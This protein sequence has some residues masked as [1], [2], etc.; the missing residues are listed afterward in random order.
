MIEKI[1]IFIV[2]LFPLIFFHELGHFFFA[3]LFKVRVSTFSIGFGRKIFTFNKWDTQ[4]AVSLIPLGGYVKMYGEDPLRREEIPQYEREFSFIHKAKWQRFLILFGGPLANFILAFVLYFGLAFQ[5][6]KVPELKIG[7]ISQ[8]SSYYE[9]GLRLG[10]TLFQ[11]NQ[12]DFLGMASLPSESETIETLTVLRNHEPY[13]FSLGMPAQA[14]YQDLFGQLTQRL[15]QPVVISSET[16]KKYSLAP[17]S[18]SASSKVKG[19]ISFEEITQYQSNSEF[20]LR[21]IADT[22]KL[23]RLTLEGSDGLIQKLKQNSLYPLDLVV[24]SVNVGSPAAKIN[25]QKNDILTH[26]NSI[27]LVSFTQLRNLITQNSSGFRLSYLRKGKAYT[28]EIMPEKK[29]INGKEIPL[30]G[31]ASQAL[32]IGNT[33]RL[34]QP[35][36]I[37]ESFSLATQRTWL[38]TKKILVGLKQLIFNEVPL[39]SL[40]GPL[41]IGK[42]ASNS[43]KISLSYFLALMAFVSINLGVFNLF[44]IPVLDGGHIVFLLFEF[45]NGGPL[46][47]R[48]VMVAQQF[49]FSLLLL[50]M[51]VALYNDV[52]A[53]F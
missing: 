7:E 33:F 31:V 46:S 27:A 18:A 52:A 2:F 24:D 23:K 30:I 51:I 28:Q 38:T 14:F 36:G 22:K 10:D 11:I 19:P 6:E 43:F 45:I 26:Y 20:V 35:Q 9:K 15:R 47:E 1:L 12:K 42:V 40:S 37:F 21:E 48:K 5:G 41:T 29:L 32:F 49:G 4:F 34:T 53:F 44:P 50:L 16:Y 3:K 25:L 39:K 8:Q 13:T 17:A